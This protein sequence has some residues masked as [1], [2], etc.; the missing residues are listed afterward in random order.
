MKYSPEGMTIAYGASALE[1][2]PI[3]NVTLNSVTFVHRQSG[4]EHH[5]SIRQ[6]DPGR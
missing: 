5:N 2:D 4:D 1:D 6:S 3:E